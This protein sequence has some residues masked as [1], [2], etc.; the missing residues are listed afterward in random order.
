[1]IK[2]I[3]DKR[4]YYDKNGKEITE[5]CQIKFDDGRIE[6]VFLTTEEELGTDATNPSWIK[7]GRAI[8]GENGI[9]P[10]TKAETE[11]CEVID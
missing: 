9:Y 4:H 7:S 11:E 1:M 5:G 6:T 3:N 2:M 10:L 8:P